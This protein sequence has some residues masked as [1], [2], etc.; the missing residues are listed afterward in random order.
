[1]TFLS[2]VIAHI[3]SD[4]TMLN[5]EIDEVDLNILSF[6]QKN[7]KTPFTKIAEKVGVSDTTIHL[8]VKKMEEI[9]ST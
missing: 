5:T 3:V 2:A 7:S 6:L 8:R 4:V 9:G 1:M